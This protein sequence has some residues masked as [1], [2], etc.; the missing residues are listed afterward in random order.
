[1]S[2]VSG[3]TQSN[4]NS[5]A[6]FDPAVI[7]RIW[8]QSATCMLRANERLLRGFMDVAK[9]QNE[10][11][12]ELLNHRLSA[13]QPI[14]NEGSDGVSSFANAQ[15]DH[16]LQGIERLTTGLR[17]V[18]HEITQCFSE[19]TK[20]L[21]EDA[22]AVAHDAAAVTQEAAKASANTIMQPAVTMA[23]KAE[24]VAESRAN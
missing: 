3:N 23:R 15:I 22:A 19:A 20:L 4:G 21:I 6:K 18:T 13:L 11:G 5:Q 16:S 24:K 12:Q 2:Q 1:M 17:E 9:R 10:L 7:L 14:R 8:Q